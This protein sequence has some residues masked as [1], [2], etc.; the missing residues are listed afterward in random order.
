MNI[1]QYYRKSASI[2]LNASLV[3]LIPS[4]FLLIYGLILKQ[5][6]R[7]V[8]LCLPFLV[9]SFICYQIYLI[10]DKRVGSSV[11]A[12]E[13]DS[14]F[15]NL[16]K[17]NQVLIT[18]LPAPS[19]R[20][21]IFNTKGQMLGEIRDLNWQRI[22]WFVPYMFDRLLFERT[23]GLFDESGQLKAKIIIQKNNIALVGNRS[24]QQIKLLR[25]THAEYDFAHEGRR[26]SVKRSMLFTDI[27]FSIGGLES[28]RAR[29]GLLP[30]EC[31]GQI[32][33]P[34]TPVLSFEEG[35]KAKDKL[36]VYALLAK[37]FHHSNH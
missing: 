9:Y 6:E 26:I 34:N 32:Q 11:K 13:S 3:S 20:M 23:Y 4:F 30:K 1:Q 21:L 14:D 22:R 17:H 36:L 12:Q 31:V 10:N 29:K 19:L 15:S 27:K 8:L 37:L 24:T 25:R 35:I 28:A 7:M 5:D 33:D 18:F 16:L 2:S